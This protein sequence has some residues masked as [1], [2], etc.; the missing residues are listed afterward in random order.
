MAAAATAPV[1]TQ[2]HSKSAVYALPQGTDE[3]RGLRPLPTAWAASTCLKGA[4]VGVADSVDP[5]RPDSSAIIHSLL[6]NKFTRVHLA[7]MIAS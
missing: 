3:L 2:W 1:C 5:G 7:S 6:H 4:R